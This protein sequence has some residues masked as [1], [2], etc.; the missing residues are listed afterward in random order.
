MIEGE[1]PGVLPQANGAKEQGAALLA[2]VVAFVAPH[3][4][5]HP[6]LVEDLADTKLTEVQVRRQQGGACA[7]SL[8][9]V[10]GVVD[11][12]AIEESRKRLISVLPSR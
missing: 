10:H 4:L 7:V 5:L 3:Q 9:A 1:V 2:S 8:L 11:Q 6:D 12:R